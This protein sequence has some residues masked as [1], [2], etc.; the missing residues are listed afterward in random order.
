MKV[1]GST[2]DTF[3]PVSAV[4]FPFDA[5]M[6][7][8]QQGHWYH[9]GTFLWPDL[10]RHQWHSNEISEEFWKPILRKL[11]VIGYRLQ[12][13]NR[14]SCLAHR[15]GG[16][17]H[18]FLSS[19]RMCTSEY[20]MGCG[21]IYAYNFAKSLFICSVSWFTQ[22]RG[23]DSCVLPLATP[24]KWSQA[25]S[26]VQHLTIDSGSFL[27]WMLVLVFLHCSPGRFTWHVYTQTCTSV[28]KV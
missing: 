24:V 9:E 13:R 12:I 15:A 8:V 2:P 11:R 5:A 3:R 6:Y 4:L 10:W 19:D 22:D 23:H 28:L 16:A 21:A 1:G 18:T 20:S 25:T 26:E 17:K 27:P 7:F 14:F